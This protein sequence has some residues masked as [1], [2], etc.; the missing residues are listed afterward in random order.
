MGPSGPMVRE[1]SSLATGAPASVVVGFGDLSFMHSSTDDVQ[2]RDAA[3]AL[4][5]TPDLTPR[6]TNR[7]YPPTPYVL[8]APV[9][10]MN[11]Q[12]R[13]PGPQGDNLGQCAM[14]SPPSFPSAP[15]FK[16]ASQRLCPRCMSVSS[17]LRRAAASFPTPASSITTW[18]MAPRGSK[19]QE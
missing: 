18:H 5:K 6:P 9:K 8:Y 17:L 10:I 3:G 4:S 7:I 19:Y 1:C 16:V 12:A 15:P 11:L 2:N 14:R 13:F